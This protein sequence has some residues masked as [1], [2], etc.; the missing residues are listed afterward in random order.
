MD[1]ENSLAIHSII[2]MVFLQIGNSRLNVLGVIVDSVEKG[3][4]VPSIGQ[5]SQMFKKRES[6]LSPKNYCYNILDIEG[7][8]VDLSSKRGSDFDIARPYSIHEPV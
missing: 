1:G 4:V 3:K 5:L 2:F 8:F 6:V 7:D